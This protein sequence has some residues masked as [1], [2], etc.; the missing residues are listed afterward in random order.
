MAEQVK[1][2]PTAVAERQPPAMT[3]FE[4]MERDF[5]EMRRRWAR[6]VR[7]PVAW[8]F[9]PL[10]PARLAAEVTWSPTVDV[11]EQDGALVIKA[12][13]PGV[14]K[15]DV[16]VTHDGLLTIRGKREE[17]KE[18]KEA[19]YYACERFSG[20]FSPSFSLPEGVDAG[21]VA[22]DY[23]DGV[24]EVRVPLPAKSTAQAVTIPVK[25]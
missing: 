12:E 22:A 18:V 24:L 10:A 9:A 17:A 15:D 3:L 16:S 1:N 6:M 11:Y 23:K 14:K 2:G 7:W 20:S 13:L 19:K 4:H 8:P 21:A 25:S 5:E